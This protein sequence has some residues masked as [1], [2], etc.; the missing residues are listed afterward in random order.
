[1]AVG[2]LGNY[3]YVSTT[4]GSV[5]AYAVSANGTLSEISGSPFSIPPTNCGLFCST[6][7]NGL[8]YDANDNSLYVASATAFVVATFTVD[9]STGA[10][11]W[12]YNTPT[13]FNPDNAAM[14]PNGQFLYVTNAA[15]HDISAY[16]ITPSATSG[17]NPEPL[18]PISGQPF[19]AGG[20]PNSLAIEPTGHYLYVN[21]STDNTISAYSINGSTG[22]LTPVNGSPFP[23]TNGAGGNSQLT[24]DVTGQYLYVANS[25]N[26]GNVCAFSI[27]QTT[28]ALTQ[29]AGSP[30][31]TEKNAAGPFQ[32]GVYQAQTPQ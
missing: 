23:I 14:S 25:T 8:V 1:M 18:T 10:L 16:L 21:N 17:G 32:I 2:P 13:H 4:T 11:T 27:D 22:A 19:A 30:Y 31:L 28:G 29:L 6:S 12:I 26:Q 15:S 7:A 3:L 5:A 9:P 20:T 24:I